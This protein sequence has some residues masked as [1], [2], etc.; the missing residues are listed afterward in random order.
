MSTAYYLTV[1]LHLLA[2]LFWLGGMFFL[3]VVGA[4]VL[5]GVEPPSLRQRLFHELGTRFRTAGW[6]AIAVLVA[7][8]TL[9]LHQ[10]ALL[11]W[12]GVLASPAFW[13]SALGRAL[14]VKLLAVA[15]M[16]GVSAVHDF[17][18]GPAAGRVEPGTARA[19]A[20][21]RHAALLA[22]MN[23][24]VGLVVVLAAVRLARGG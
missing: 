9:I 20:L 14:A 21:R 15:V 19:I 8:G 12:Q 11:H 24:L 17:V 5:R 3:G 2:A 1:T 22:R 23:A 10:R 13:S 6:V 4:P 18:L 7:T 16:V